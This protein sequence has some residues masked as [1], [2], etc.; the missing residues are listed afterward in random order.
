MT[1]MCSGLAVGSLGL[2]EDVCV[3]V[4]EGVSAVCVCVCL[5]R[6][7]GTPGAGGEGE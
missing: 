4:R 1:L 5:C 7:G 6:E 3:C 2:R